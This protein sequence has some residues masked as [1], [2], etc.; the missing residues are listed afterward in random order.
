VQPVA[1]QPMIDSSGR[2]AIMVP[3]P[4]VGEII[5]RYGQVGSTAP[6]QIIRPMTEDM[7]M[8]RSMRAVDTVRLIDTVRVSTGVVDLPTDMST[9]VERMDAMERRLNE[10]MDRMMAEADMRPEARPAEPAATPSQPVRP[11][12]DSRG[13]FSRIAS[14]RT[15]DFM[16]FAGI[17]GGDGAQFVAG[18]RADLGALRPG[19]PFDL[20]PEL[21]V[22]SGS[23]NTS[24]LAMTHLRYSVMQDQRLRPYVMAGAG[25]FSETVLGLSTSLGAAFDLQ[26]G[27]G[28]SFEAVAELQG[29]NLFDR[30]RLLFGIRL[31]R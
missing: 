27:S 14:A 7:A 29:I 15:S 10:R 19:S 21:S 9:L 1:M 20:V 17:G 23:G 30:S 5:I 28:R 24:V 25:I 16:P 11:R 22:A 31:G 4:N 12:S 3:A 8:Q 6:V 13:L 26:R 18:G 2:T